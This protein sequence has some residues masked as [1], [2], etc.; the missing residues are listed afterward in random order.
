[1]KN[2]IEKMF[3][4]L[5]LKHLHILNCLIL[6]HLNLLF[7]IYLNIPLY[8]QYFHFFFI[9]CLNKCSVIFLFFDDFLSFN[10]FINPLLESLFFLEYKPKFFFLGGLF[11]FL[12]KIFFLDNFNDLLFFF[13]NFSFF[14]IL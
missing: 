13:W 3:F 2:N 10:E 1:M 9:S 6:H 7:D 5:L 8:F 11:K 14:L 12:M 4:Y